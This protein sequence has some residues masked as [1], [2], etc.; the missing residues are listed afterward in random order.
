MRRSKNSSEGF[1]ISEA[2]AVLLVAVRFSWPLNPL[3]G[4]FNE[5]RTA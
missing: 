2:L 4:T 5:L 3:K 1:A